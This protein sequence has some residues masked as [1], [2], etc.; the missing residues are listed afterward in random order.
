[1]VLFHGFFE[2]LPLCFELLLLSVSCATA[3]ALGWF[4]HLA[5][6]RS[7]EDHATTVHVRDGGCACAHHLIPHDEELLPYQPAFWEEEGEQLDPSSSSLA[8]RL[9]VS[10]WHYFAVVALL[11]WLHLCLLAMQLGFYLALYR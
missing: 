11:S 3:L 10:P 9:L 7:K 4:L 6:Q 1:M 8:K 5:W 2:L